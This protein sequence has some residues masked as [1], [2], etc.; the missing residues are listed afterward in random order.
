MQLAKLLK[1]IT[2]TSYNI[3]TK[4][5]NR[6]LFGVFTVM[7]FQILEINLTYFA[8]SLNSKFSL[9]KYSKAC[10]VESLNTPIRSDEHNLNNDEKQYIKH[11]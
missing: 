8:V 11:L 3:Y 2:R 6:P 9:E 1:L 5:R 10:A 4:T 7:I